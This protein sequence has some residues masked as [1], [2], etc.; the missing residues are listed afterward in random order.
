MLLIKK[1]LMLDYQTIKPYIT[2]KNSMIYILTSLVMGITTQN[3]YVMSGILIFAIITMYG[4][5]LFAVG[6]QNGIDV[7][8]CSLPITRKNLVQGRYLF[9]GLLTLVSTL[10]A[11]ILASGV[12]LALFP[13]F[14][15]EDCLVLLA[16]CG[17][18]FVVFLLISFLQLPFFFKL[19]YK[20]ANGPTML[21]TMLPFF[22]LGIFPQWIPKGSMA[23]TMESLL[24]VALG[25]GAGLVAIV[26]L[27]SYFLSQRW[28]AKRE[29]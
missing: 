6:E 15:F 24:R 5:F 1:C 19:G 27:G 21:V 11:W 10:L 13:G 17:V 25:V 9:M 23:P 8:Y 29:F 16:I 7:L 3:V 20:K 14:A 4:R 28:Y 12:G 22:L 18:Y 26:P 2:L